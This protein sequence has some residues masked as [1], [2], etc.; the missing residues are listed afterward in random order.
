MGRHPKLALVVT[1]EQRTELKRLAAAH[2]TP[3]TL[4]K[5]VNIIVGKKKT[6]TSFFQSSTA[7]TPS[8]ARRSSSSRVN[9]AFSKASHSK[10]RAWL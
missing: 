10:P 7:T 6:P 1:D 3:Q 5:R 2:L 4:A 8:S 9:V